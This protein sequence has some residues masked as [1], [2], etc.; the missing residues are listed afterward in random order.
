M[1]RKGS[2][3][4]HTQTHTHDHCGFIHTFWS[5]SHYYFGDPLHSY[6]LGK[7][8]QL[9]FMKQFAGDK[10]TPIGYETFT[11]LCRNGGS[12]K[13]KN[14]ATASYRAIL[15]FTGSYGASISTH[16]C[17]TRCVWSLSGLFVRMNKETRK[18][19]TSD[20]HRWPLHRW[21]TRTAP[22]SSATSRR[23]WTRA[24]TSAA[25]SSSPSCSSRRP[26]TSPSKVSDPSGSHGNREHTDRNTFR[27]RFM[28]A[29]LCCS[30]ALVNV[31]ESDCEGD[32]AWGS[33]LQDAGEAEGEGGRRLN[34]LPL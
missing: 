27:S 25:C 14:N 16:C 1:V 10:F 23:G 4:K 12:N 29:W 34:A 5:L 26:S 6:G 31:T 19:T 11:L 17:R 30:E 32:G 22:W 20:C 15:Q 8:W 3:S 24:P 2:P 13:I 21:C 18:G 28:R 33:S 9:H 7:L